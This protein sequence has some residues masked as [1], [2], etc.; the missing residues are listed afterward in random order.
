MAW[1]ENKMP[2]IRRSEKR[3]VLKKFKKSLDELGLSQEEK[4][5]LMKLILK[6]YNL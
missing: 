5:N 3:R 4:D 6:G 1:H 2:A